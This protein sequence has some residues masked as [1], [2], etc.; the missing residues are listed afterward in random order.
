MSEKTSKLKNRIKFRTP[1]TKSLLY[2]FLFFL[3]CSAISVALFKISEKNPHVVEEYYN[4]IV[5]KAITLP[6]KMFVSIFPF[7]VSEIALV[8]VILFVITYFI[9]TVVLTVKRMRK[10]QGKIYIPAVRYILSIGILITGIITMFVVNGGLNYNGITFA[11][12]S[13]LVLTETSTEELEE[14]CMFLGEQAAKA[15]KLLPENDKGVISPDVSVFELAKK[16]KDGY[17][18][19]EDTYPYLKGFYPKAKPAIFSHFMCYT[20]I[21][22]I[23]PYII[24]EPNINYKTPIMSLPS[25]INHEM[26]HQRGISREDEANFIAY[27]A[28]INNPDPLFQYSGYYLALNYSLNALSKHNGDAS[29]RVYEALDKGILRDMQAAREFWKQFETPKNIVATVSENV[30]NKYLETVN[31][32][33]G[34]H[35][36]GRMVDLLLAYRRAEKEAN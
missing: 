10:K 19:I 2:I 28:S 13:G 18:A 14:L 31:V 1:S 24:P 8:T 11:D 29:R 27:L 25:T 9:R 20:E 17:K 33:D 12:R 7:S 4:S 22:G 30:N 23:Y 3:V 15:R 36:Y 16:A 34:V 35:S 5:F 6:S 32:E 21:T 26:A